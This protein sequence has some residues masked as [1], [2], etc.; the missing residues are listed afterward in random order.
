MHNF[1]CM[2]VFSCCD[3]HNITTGFPARKMEKG[4]EE[5]VRW[6]SG[7]FRSPSRP[8]DS[9]TSYCM[10]SMYKVYKEHNL[11]FPS[12]GSRIRGRR[13]GGMEEV[14]QRSLCKLI[15]KKN[16]DIQYPW[17]MESASLTESQDDG[18]IEQAGAA[19]DKMARWVPTYVVQRHKLFLAP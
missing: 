18:W 7:P 14:V 3:D 12:R 6:K 1:T 10:L 8:L 19:G 2:H 9:D 17:M 11:D 13:D 5:D 4:E 15:R 16:P